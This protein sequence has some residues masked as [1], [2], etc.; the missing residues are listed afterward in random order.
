MKKKK[1]GTYIPLPVVPIVLVG[2]KVKGHPNYATVGL[3]SGLNINPPIIGISLNNNHHST[4][5][6][7]ENKTFSI[8]IPSSDYVVETDYCGLFSGR[9]VDK[10]ALFNT[11]FGELKSAPMIE[12][13][14]I[15]C[16]CKFTGQTINFGMDSLFVGEVVQV[17]VNEEYLDQNDRIDIQKV[18]PI[19]YSGLENLYRGL[20]KGLGNGW[21]IGRKLINKADSQINKSK[22]YKCK[23]VERN[24]KSVLC[25]TKTVELHKIDIEIGVAID[26]ILRY[27]RTRAYS[28]AGAPYVTYENDDGINQKIQV[29]IPFNCEL[30]GEG[31]IKSSNIPGGKMATYLHKGPYNELQKIR[32]VIIKSLENENYSIRGEVYEFY[33]NDPRKTTPENLKTEIMIPLK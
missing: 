24:S 29:G 1:T 5:G 2:T 17:Y 6:L 3:V 28:P 14:P 33:K 10:S 15:T 8:N 26:E 21:S 30:I 4:L 23:I 16:E 13:F 22:E 31:N 20:G 7:L 25:I 11:F 9:D 19:Y 18:N 32:S 12:E 27:A